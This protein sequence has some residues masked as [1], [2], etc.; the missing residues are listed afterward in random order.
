MEEELAAVH[1]RRTRGQNARRPARRP[2]VARPDPD[3]DLDQRPAA[4][5]QACRL[6]PFAE[7]ARRRR[8]LLLALVLTTTVIGLLL[9]GRIVAAR[10]PEILKPIFLPCFALLFA[11]IALSF[12]S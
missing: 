3:R 12:W 1:R 6:D 2:A 9:M 11:W 5:T 7:R 4:M 8:L 10:G